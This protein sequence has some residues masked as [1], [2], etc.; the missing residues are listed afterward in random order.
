M[1][2]QRVLTGFAAGVM[3]AASIWSLLVPAM[4][5]SYEMGRLAFVPAFFG[6]W[7]GILFLLLLDR[8]V[9]HL[10]QGSDVP[11][12]PRATFKKTTMLLLAVTLHNIPC[13]LYT[14]IPSLPAMLPAAHRYIQLQIFRSKEHGAKWG[15]ADC[16]PY[17]TEQVVW[18]VPRFVPDPCEMCLRLFVGLE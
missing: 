18:C 6:F 3:T 5:Q 12:G 4:D 11:E 2:V 15:K 9:P 8:L 14:S 1:G 7:I 13:L 10:H 17:M 16:P